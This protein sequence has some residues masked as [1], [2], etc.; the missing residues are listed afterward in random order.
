M[1]AVGKS[2]YVVPIFVPHLGCPHDCIFCNQKRISGIK[3]PLNSGDLHREIESI[4]STL[5]YSN[6]PRVEIAFFGG[7][8]TGIELAL[9][10]DYLSI[11]KTYIDKGLVDGLRLSTRP[12]YID[13][14]I[15]RRLKQYGV[16]TIELGVQSM[17]QDVLEAS[18]RGHTVASVVQASK[19]IK[20][21]GFTLGH[22]LMP[23]LP[24]D[25]VERFK[26]TVDLSV[27]L[28]PDVMRFYPTLV[29]KE[30]GLADA[31]CDKRYEAMSLEE[32]TC[33]CA[34]GLEKCLNQ[35]I[36]VIRIGL[37][38]TESVCD[39]GDVLAG[40]FHPSFR[41]LVEGMVFKK[42]VVEALKILDVS[43]ET[44]KGQ[45]LRLTC[46]ANQVSS[47]SGLNKRNKLALIEAYGF[48]KINIIGADQMAPY[49]IMVEVF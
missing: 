33:A 46:S 41:Q 26:E 12:D 30:T 42:K 31:F 3:A 13:E 7:S 49:T 6:N 44:C 2:Y 39:D 23:G 22:Q 16:E 34:Y 43:S 36:R 47:V 19:M 24:G 5:D 17:H 18:N 37:Q 20:D 28:G 32:A 10:E 29:I 27:A 15:L 9:Q 25:T 40:P 11:G 38:A 35:G 45:R 21:Y 14:T 4:L 48:S 8:F 1:N